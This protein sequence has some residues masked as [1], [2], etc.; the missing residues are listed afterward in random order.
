MIRK[1]TS[2]DLDILNNYLYKRK[3][4]NLFMISDIE[5]FGFEDENLEIFID[6]YNNELKTVYLRYFNNLCVVSYD[7]ILDLDFIKNIVEKH[8]IVN[9]SGEKDLIQLIKL[10]GFITKDCY[11]SSL[12]KLQIKVDTTGVCEL[13]IDNFEEYLEKSNEVFN[14]NTKVESIKAELEKNSKHIFVYKENGEVVSGVSSSAE[15]K[16]LAMLLGVFTL[17]KWRRRGLA[18][19]C[20]YAICEKLLNEGKT[21]CLF[22]DNPNAAKMYEKLGFKFAGYFSILRRDE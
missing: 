16:E 7:N 22:Y 21:V 15:S 11:F 12:N 4:L 2:C 14:T 8:S 13:T 3:E 1:C 5:I 10:D 17:E 19:K 6:Q 9:I 18:L 20:V